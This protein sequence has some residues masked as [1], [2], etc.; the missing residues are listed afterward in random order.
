MRL[1]IYTVGMVHILL[2]FSFFEEFFSSADSCISTLF[3]DVTSKAYPNRKPGILCVR[4][5]NTGATDTRGVKHSFVGRG[6]C[7]SA[8]LLD[9]TVIF[10]FNAMGL[11]WV[12]AYQSCRSGNSVL[13]TAGTRQLIPLSFRMQIFSFQPESSM[14]YY[15]PSWG[16][17][18]SCSSCATHACSCF[19][20]HVCSCVRAHAF[21]C[22]GV[23]PWGCVKD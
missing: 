7:A 1:V 9:F 21:M 3:K 22:V 18:T 8:T 20:P 11:A 13:I 17:K 12:C 6:G 23:G 15:T 5:R 4:T 16:M 19:R 2:V 14:F 10:Q